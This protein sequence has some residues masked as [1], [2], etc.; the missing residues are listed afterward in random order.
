MD[1]LLW[2]QVTHNLQLW[3][4]LE[5]TVSSRSQTCN[6]MDLKLTLL[7]TGKI[8]TNLFEK[9]QTLYLYIPPGSAHSKGMIKGL[10]FGNTLRIIRL[11]LNQADATIHL[12]NFKN[13]LIARGYT[14]AVLTPLFLQALTHAR[15]FVNKR[16]D[17]IQHPPQ[18]D[19]SKVFLHL[20]FH[21]EDPNSRAIHRGW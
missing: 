8:E 20:E 7:A 5:W 21:P 19:T 16:E 2:S 1:A 9:S 3:H 17:S 18:P 15:D 10:I 6:F 12:L 4:G 13:Q 11:C 14:S